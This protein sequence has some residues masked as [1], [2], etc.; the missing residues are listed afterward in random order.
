[1]LA[2]PRGHVGRRLR[3]WAGFLLGETAHLVFQFA[4]V[5]TLLQAD[6]DQERQVVQLAA[7]LGRH[8]AHRPAQGR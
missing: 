5:G 8:D 4:G 2:A 1:M 6:L 7:V 3:R